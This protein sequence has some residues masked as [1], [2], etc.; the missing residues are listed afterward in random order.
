M[1]AFIPWQIRVG[2]VF[3]PDALLGLTVVLT[4]LWAL[5]LLERPGL[6][7][8]ILAG[9]G[10]AL[11]M[12][13]KMT[14]GV[15]AIPLAT[16]MVWR[17]RR[18]LRRLLWLGVAG[19]ASALWFVLLNPYWYAYPGWLAGLRRDYA[20]R[21]EVRGLQSGEIP[22]Q[23]LEFPTG[24]YIFGMVLGLVALGGYLALVHGLM[25]GSDS[26]RRHRAQLLML[27]VFPPL[28]TTIYL[29]QTP[30][31]KPNN[32]LPIVPILALGASYLLIRLSRRIADLWSIQRH[33]VEWVVIIAVLCWVGTSGFLFVYRSL[34]P[35]TTN[36]A[37]EF[38]ATR[39]KVKVGRYVFG[40]S[41]PPQLPPWGGPIRYRRTLPVLMP[42]GNRETVPRD[43]L[44][45]ADG[46]IYLEKGLEREF[47]KERA[48]RVVDSDRR[49]IQ[50]R[51][52]KMRGPTLAVLRHKF[53][54]LVAYQ[55]E[56]EDCG[57][58]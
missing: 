27:V 31:F 37:L 47:F 49:I 45:L 57:E 15:L 58:W 50:N 9:L 30:Y 44:D 46:E 19:L 17:W 24:P 52:F 39:T 43:S 16:A 48:A 23:V 21:A 53:R 20:M 12:S 54:G 29:I 13:A 4:L 18:E 28:F 35:T 36:A 2:G 51:L 32:F 40:E 25:R 56:S 55:L 42:L 1:L 10:I 8:A 41:V 34:V 22:G 11:A 5:R 26:G 38:L 7:S 14:G 6:G 33:S 3:K